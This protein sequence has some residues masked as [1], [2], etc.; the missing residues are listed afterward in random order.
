MKFQS[1]QLDAIVRLL[2]SPDFKVF[3]QALGDYSEK[4]MEGLVYAQNETLPNRQGKCQALAAIVKA[5]Q[6]APDTLKT[7][8]TRGKA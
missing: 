5:L 4:E 2:N 8:Q 1:N 6:S 3:M 7:L